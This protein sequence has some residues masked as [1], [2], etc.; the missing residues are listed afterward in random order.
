MQL[1]A[2]NAYFMESKNQYAVEM[3]FSL[4]L[5]LFPLTVVLSVGYDHLVNT[6]RLI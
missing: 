5:H 3:V 4:S 2:F 1:L 6:Y